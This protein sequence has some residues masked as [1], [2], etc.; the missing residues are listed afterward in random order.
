MFQCLFTMSAVTWELLLDQVNS[1]WEAGNKTSSTEEL[2]EGEIFPKG[3]T[4]PLNSKRIVSGQLEALVKVLN[5]PNGTSNEETGQ[6]F[7][8]GV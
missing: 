5:L 4:H 3:M 1:N 2:S 8:I 7:G 6:V